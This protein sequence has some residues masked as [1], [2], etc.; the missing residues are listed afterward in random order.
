M[1][2]VIVT[3]VVVLAFASAALC[4]DDPA[5]LFSDDFST[6]DPAWGNTGDSRIQIGGNKMV[7]Q[8]AAHTSYDP[9]YQGNLFNDVDIR[10]KVAQTKGA[11]DEPGGIAFWA[12][13]NSNFYAAEIESEGQVAVH[14]LTNSKW[15]NPVGWRPSDAV[16]KGIGQVNELR[17]V[18]KGKTATF[19]VNDKEVVTF[20]GFP[21]DGG[22]LV[23][24]HGESNDSAYTWEF[25]DFVVRKP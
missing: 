14:R 15:L 4:A 25:T 5:V 23:G 11:M 10:V 3:A 8:P 1:R 2:I 17:V 24:L 18:T 12:S 6:F 21:P 13:D 16:K 22:S 9:L 20:K 7:L 19:Y